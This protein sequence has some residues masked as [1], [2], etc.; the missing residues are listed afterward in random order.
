[1][2]DKILEYFDER[3]A[4]IQSD[5]AE[6]LAGTNEAYMQALF[7]LHEEVHLMMVREKL[8]EVLNGRATQLRREERVLGKMFDFSRLRG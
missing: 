3:M 7:E 5:H 1:M 6:I 2:K 4:D 8:L